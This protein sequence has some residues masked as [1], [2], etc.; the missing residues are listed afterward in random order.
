M[1]SFLLLSSVAAAAQAASEYQFSSSY[2]N[3]FNNPRISSSTGGHA[4]CIEGSIPI[5]AS[6]N[7]TKLNYT[8]PANQTIVTETIVEMF[9]INS[10]LAKQTVA[11]PHLVRGTWDIYGKLCYPVETRP[12]PE[13]LQFLIHGVG[14]DRSYWDVAANY[15]YVDAAALAGYTTFSYDRLGIGMSATPDPINIVQSQLEVAIAHELIQLLR[16]GNI[17][18]CA[19]KKVVS[20]GHSFGSIQTVG[21]TSQHPK[22]LDAAVLT[23]FSTSAA[24]QPSFFA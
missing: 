4:V 3:G 23:G 2:L 19:F 10:T 24:G 8:S 5:T 13:V 6:A 16:A 17:S 12:N 20:V 7:N 22:D 15:S 14:F 11:G 21:L 9:Q 1:R 18:N